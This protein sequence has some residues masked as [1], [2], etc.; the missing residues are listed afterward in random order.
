MPDASGPVT[1]CDDTRAVFATR[2]TGCHATTRTGAA[3]SGAT[4]GVD[5]DTYA[6]AAASAEAARQMV[7]SG[8]MPPA[9]RLPDA[10]AWTLVWWAD[11]GAP[12]G[13]CAP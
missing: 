10:E 4:E 11:Q 6:A 5:F 2:C 1:W 8:Q 9:G 13:D 7:Q 12:E 3:R